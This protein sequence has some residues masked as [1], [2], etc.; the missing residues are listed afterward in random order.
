MTYDEIKNMLDNM[1]RQA[2]KLQS[3]SKYL[4]SNKSGIRGLIFKILW[5]VYALISILFA[6][7]PFY[8]KYT[9]IIAICYIIISFI[10][11]LIILKYFE[12]FL[13]KEKL[14]KNSAYT[15]F[16]I[17]FIK[18][19]LTSKIYPAIECANLESQKNRY[20]Y[21][22][23]LSIIINIFVIPIIVNKFQ[24]I[25]LINLVLLM[26]V[27][28]MLAVIIDIVITILVRKQT[29]WETIKTY[30]QKIKIELEFSK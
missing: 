4:F 17:T 27:I 28:A 10:F 26:S 21:L 15:N 29:R 12:N 5:S 9:T 16:K 23:I 6:L 3:L 24:N 18:N 20:S 2:V 11:R 19:N 1:Y 8:L 7:S 14:N 13:A 30:L 25:K 22:R